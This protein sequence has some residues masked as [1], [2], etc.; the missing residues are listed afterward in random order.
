[1]SMKISLD[2]FKNLDAKD[3][4]S[5][6]MPVQLVMLLGMS[7][8]IVVLGYF[9]VLDGQRDV[10]SQGRL[11]EES[12]KQAFLEKKQKAINLEAY[13][14]QLND[15]QLAFGALLKQLP[16][17]AEMESLITEISQAG[18]GRGLQSDLFRPAQNEVKTA[19]FAERP[20]ELIVVGSYHDLAAFV[21]DIAQL[22]RIVTLEDIQI[23][24]VSG[25]QLSLH[26][27]AKTYRAL[28]A[29]EVNAAKKKSKS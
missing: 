18:V 8:L 26:A 23:T 28:D 20:I 27:I 19:E 1:M 14:E 9:L 12:L 16:S 11:Q 15:I 22:S 6:P 3:I 10:L 2:D 25:G 17:K 24:P 7:L 4:G 5:W 21:S 29:E 13:K